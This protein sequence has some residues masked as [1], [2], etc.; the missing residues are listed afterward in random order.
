VTFNLEYVQ[1]RY[2]FEPPKFHY[3]Y[4]RTDYKYYNRPDSRCRGKVKLITARE[5]PEGQQRY[6]STL[7]L[8]SALNG[9]EW[10]TPRSSRFT[11]GEELGTHCAGS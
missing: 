6:S 9:G 2:K 8:T 1:R 10:S 4:V 3:V 5:D 11:P 7:Y